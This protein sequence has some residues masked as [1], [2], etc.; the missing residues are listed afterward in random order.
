MN[1]TGSETRASPFYS[2]RAID[3]ENNA[4]CPAKTS[5]AEEVFDVVED[6]DIKAMRFQYALDRSKDAGVSSR[7]MI[8]L[9]LAIVYH[10]RTGVLP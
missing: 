4:R 8:R 7:T 5:A 9:P 2:T 3:V 10:S 6:S 1:M